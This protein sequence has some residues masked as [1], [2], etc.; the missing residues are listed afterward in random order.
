MARAFIIDDDHISTENL[1]DAI[2]QNCKQITSINCFDKPLDA[3]APIQ[4]KEADLV[5]LDIEMP[6]L[7]AFELIELLE[8]EWWPPIIFTTAYSQYA[9]KAFKVRAIDYLLKPIDDAELKTAV[10]HAL[11]ENRLEN[12][13]KLSQL[14]SH[15][16]KGFDDRI[17]LASGQSYHFVKIDSIVRIEGSGSYTHFYLSDGKKITA[18]KSLGYFDNRLRQH[19]FMRPH[20]SHLANMDY[21]Q[22]YSKTNGG[23]LQMLNGHLVPVSVR[24]KNEVLTALGIK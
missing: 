23:E 17:A 6:Q 24:R 12:E 22:G 5:F 21:I 8:P 4:Q 11:E 18:S 14:I 13:Q 7:N 2:A 19:K 20:Q 3:I 10:T 16:P 9:V 15:P 1:K